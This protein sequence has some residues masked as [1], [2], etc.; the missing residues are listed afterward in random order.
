MFIQEAEEAVLLDSAC[1]GS[2]DNTAVQT[3]TKDHVI[4][5]KKEETRK[6]PVRTVSV[7]IQTD[8]ISE[9]ELLSLQQQKM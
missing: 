6:E 8:P 1:G 4:N 7:E 5:E 9:L 3:P 2:N